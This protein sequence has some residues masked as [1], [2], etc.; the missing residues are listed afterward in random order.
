MLEQLEENKPVPQE[1]DRE[2]YGI[3]RQSVKEKTTTDKNYKTV[4]MYVMIIITVVLLAYRIEIFELIDGTKVEGIT[5]H[6]GTY[7]GEVEVMLYMA[8]EA[9]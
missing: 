6:G 5:W 4:I 3:S 7:S 1:V 9:G 8:R 2:E